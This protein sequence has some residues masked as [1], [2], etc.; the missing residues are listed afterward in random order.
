MSIHNALRRRITPTVPLVLHVE[1]SDRGSFDVS[2]RLAF[3]LNAMALVEEKTGLNM[4]TGEAFKEP[5]ASRT[6]ILLWAAVQENNP[7]Y[8]GDG[9]LYAIRSFLTLSNAQEVLT[10]IN[11]AFIAAL[12]REQVAA[13]KAAAEGVADPQPIPVSQ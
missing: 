2:F 11:E 13:M 10:A 5:N 8:A 9:G 3:D 7:E 4:L 6:S 1:D 12:P